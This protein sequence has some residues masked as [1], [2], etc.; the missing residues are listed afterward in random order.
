M[1]GSERMRNA[2]RLWREHRTCEFPAPLRG[3]E[4]EGI[5]LVMLDADTAGCVHAWIR[6][7]GALD[8]ERG[9][10]LR[11]CVEDLDRVT[12]RISDPAGR[13]YYERLHRLAVLV[14]KAHDTA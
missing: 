9:R 10:I 11:T 6:D 7:G 13:R 8:P 12:A 5:D 14:A 1:T 4:V 3:A 2:A